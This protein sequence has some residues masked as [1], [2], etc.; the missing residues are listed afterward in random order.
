VSEVRTLKIKSSLASKLARPGGRTLQ[1]AERLAQA[2][3]DARRDE[4]MADIGA[5][6][7]ELERVCAAKAPGSEG[8]VY[9]LSSTIIDMAGF[10]DTGPLYDAAYS[11]C[12]LSEQ[13][14]EEGGTWRWPPVE[15]HV[16]TLRLIHAGGCKA[17]PEAAALLR[18]LS[19]MVKAMT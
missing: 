16:Q 19:A 18:G 7:C 15:V 17:G 13:T 10:F 5:A 12:D 6:I 1:D 11:L 14:G 3:L 2:S 9:A 4:V 8:R